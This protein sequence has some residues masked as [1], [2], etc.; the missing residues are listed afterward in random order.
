VKFTHTCP[1]LQRMVLH[2]HTHVLM[3]YALLSTTYCNRTCCWGAIQLPVPLA[4]DKLLWQFLELGPGGRAR[5][6]FL[7]GETD[8]RARLIIGRVSKMVQFLPV[9]TLLSGQDATG[10][11]QCCSAGRDHMAHTV[12]PHGFQSRVSGIPVTMGR[13]PSWPTLNSA[14]ACSRWPYET[15][16]HANLERMSGRGS[17]HQ[18]T[19]ASKIGKYTLKTQG[20]WIGR[21]RRWRARNSQKAAILQHRRPGGMPPADGPLMVKNGTP[22]EGHTKTNTEEA[23]KMEEACTV[24]S[25]YRRLR[26]VFRPMLASEVISK[27]PKSMVYMVA[28]FG[29]EVTR[30]TTSLQLGLANQKVGGGTSASLLGTRSRG[31]RTYI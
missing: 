8:Q 29:G 12:R 25:S 23:C 24:A 2:I 4:V 31:H 27:K 7:I 11:E 14:Q 15:E 22:T 30:C 19:T 5:M 9:N 13:H 28:A 26:N 18:K 3:A 17:M 21:M 20:V 16:R 6:W 10:N 1:I